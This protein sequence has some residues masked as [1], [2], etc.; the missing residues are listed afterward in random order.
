MQEIKKSVTENT[1]TVTDARTVPAR[2]DTFRVGQRIATQVRTVT[3]NTTTK[4]VE[5]L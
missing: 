5:E 1:R 3:T 2:I 4:T